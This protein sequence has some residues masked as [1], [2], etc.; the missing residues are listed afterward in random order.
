MRD[1]V[2]EDDVDGDANISVTKDYV[3]TL[4]KV[5]YDVLEYQLQSLLEHMGYNDDNINIDTDI[6]KFVYGLMIKRIEEK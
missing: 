6:D 5:K 1:D 4:V 2:G 3:D